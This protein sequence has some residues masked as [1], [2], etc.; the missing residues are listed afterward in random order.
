VLDRATGKLVPCDAK[1]CPYAIDGVNHA[2]YAAFG[3]WSG[4]I[5][6][7]AKPKVKDAAYAF[8]S[9]MSQPAQSDVDVTIGKSGFNPYRVTQF[10]YNDT[11]KKAGMSKVAG[12]SYL[13]AIKDSLDSPNMILD[14]RIPQNQKYQ[15]VV[16]DE[17]IARFLSGEIDKEQTVKAVLD[18]WNELNEQIGV[19]SQ[20]KFYKGSL[21]IQR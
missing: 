1:T 3:G 14:L 5:N 12:D 7:K 17:A 20:L 11:W 6:A 8:L 18:G 15:Q 9:Y 21:G 4:G 13:G 10:T 16:L 19:E 2:P